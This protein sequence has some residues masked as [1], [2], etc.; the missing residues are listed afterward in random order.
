MKI[1]NAC[2]ASLASYVYFQSSISVRLLVPLYSHS[3][4]CL[5]MNSSA[6]SKRPINYIYSCSYLMVLM[7]EKTTYTSHEM[8]RSSV[9]TS[10]FNNFG[11]I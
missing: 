10:F 9:I 8:D 6:N 4:I 11:E 2:S 3:H 5:R 7:N 1:E